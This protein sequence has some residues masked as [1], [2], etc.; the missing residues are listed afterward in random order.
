[1]QKQMHKRS[2]QFEIVALIRVWQLGRRPICN[3]L[4]LLE[5]PAVFSELHLELKLIATSS[6]KCIGMDMASLGPTVRYKQRERV[7]LFASGYKARDGSQHHVVKLS[8]RDFSVFQCFRVRIQQRTTYRYTIAAKSGGNYTR[9]A[10]SSGQLCWTLRSQKAGPESR[11][12]ESPLISSRKTGQG[13][14]EQ[15]H[16]VSAPQ[17]HKCLCH[18]AF[19]VTY[20]SSPPFPSCSC[21]PA[22]QPAIQPSSEAA[23]AI[24]DKNGELLNV[25]VRYSA[26]QCISVQVKPRLQC[27]SQGTVYISMLCLA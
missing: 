6:V 5:Q 22:I 8:G 11:Q 14:V 9:P 16:E 13:R 2:L 12:Q 1:M 3:K 27:N 17:S 4:E 23:A 19:T 25:A 20:I 10:S 15:S 7:L 21:H 26:V 18:H 24:K